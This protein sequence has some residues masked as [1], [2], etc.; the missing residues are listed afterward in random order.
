MTEEFISV[1]DRIISTSIDIIS[2]SGLSALSFKSISLKTNISE[3]L[4]YK[5]YL[6]TDEILTDI[7]KSFFKFDKGLFK[8]LSSKECSHVEKIE[9]YLEAFGSYFNSYYSISCLILH[10]E[11][12]LHNAH[13]RE[14]VESG[15]MSRRLFMID[16]FN[17]AIEN[18]EIRTNLSAEQLTDNV[19]GYIFIN[20]F[21]R[22]IMI[23]KH[24]I[25]DDM[26]AYFRGMLKS[27]KAI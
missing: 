23:N 18:H 16:L 19:F 11:E 22:R 3:D 26:L 12:L 24:S 8:T 14:I 20:L 2:D 10:Y 21:N 27:I 15:H 1:Q 4:L 6:N 7:V 25:K 17:G 9:L 13:T 5:Y